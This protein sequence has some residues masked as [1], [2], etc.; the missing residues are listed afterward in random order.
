MLT[1]AALGFFNHLLGGESWARERLAAFAGKAVRLQ[2]GGDRDIVATIG[3]TGLLE[4]GG[5]PGGSTGVT[6][7]LPADAPA[8]WIVD[9]TSLFSSVSIAGSADLAETLG[10]VVRN[11]HWDIEHDLSRV[12]GDIPARRGVQLGRRFADWHLRSAERL[13]QV[14]ADYLT[15]EAA[16]VAKRPEVEA[17]CS[18]VDAL[19]DDLA[20]LEKRVQRLESD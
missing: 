1:G 18:E 14:A 7:S 3:N 8:R 19:R 13:A 10:F 6:V 17:F 5:D 15:G 16:T 20:R 2:F 12:V 9:R 11:L 4:R